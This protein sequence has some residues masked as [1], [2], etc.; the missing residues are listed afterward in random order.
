MIA[1]CSLSTRRRGS[2]PKRPP[3]APLSSQD[4]SCGAS[5]EMAPEGATHQSTAIHTSAPHHRS[6]GIWNGAEATSNRQPGL[7]S[8]H[9]E[10][11]G[12]PFVGLA[13]ASPPH[14]ASARQP[15]ARRTYTWIIHWTIAHCA[16]ARKDTPE[17]ADMSYSAGPFIGTPTPATRVLLW[18]SSCV[19]PLSAESD[20]GAVGGKPPSAS[21]H[22]IGSLP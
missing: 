20:I 13:R 12:I 7:S 8:P 21:V 9:P 2:L 15:T 3:S 1:L 16:M 18:V 14:P 4:C 5:H 17:P 11:P 6:V 19:Q 10:Q 22:T